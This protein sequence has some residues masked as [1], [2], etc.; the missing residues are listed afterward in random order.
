LVNGG[1]E[2]GLTGWTSSGSVT[3]VDYNVSAGTRSA[4][5]GADTA[6]TDS[7]LGQTFAAT[8]GKISFSY[9]MI[10]HDIVYWDWFTVSLKDL[11]TGQSVTV[12]APMCH[13]TA[14]QQ[15]SA[16]LTIGH[17]YQ[18][19][20]LNHDDDWADDASWSFVDEVTIGT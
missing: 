19:T 11:T 14:Y 12:I 3:A 4:K 2:S 16:S 20:F 15:A 18:I 13:T 5:L 17:R 7:K 1:F 10:C 8:G 6:T 9:R